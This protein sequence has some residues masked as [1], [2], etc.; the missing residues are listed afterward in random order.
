[1]RSVKTF[2]SESPEELNKEIKD[3]LSEGNYTEIE[4][5]SQGYINGGWTT[6]ISRVTYEEEFSLVDIVEQLE[7]NI[8]QNQN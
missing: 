8:S 3:F 2:Q 6:Y 1:M 7:R 5:K 4:R